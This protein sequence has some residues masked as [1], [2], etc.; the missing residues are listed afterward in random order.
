MSLLDKDLQP[1]MGADVLYDDNQEIRELIKSRFPN[2]ELDP[3]YDCIHEH[4]LGVKVECSERDWLSFVIME[5][6]G[7]ISLCCQIRILGSPDVIGNLLDEIDP[8]WRKRRAESKGE[9]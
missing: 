8:D 2:A 3:S 7:S 1:Q 5:G 6:L 4:R 9:K